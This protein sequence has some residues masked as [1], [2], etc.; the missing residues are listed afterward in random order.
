MSES[1]SHKVREFTEQAGDKTCPS[2]PKPMSREAAL[3]ITRMIVSELDELLCTVSQTPE[4]RD[5]LLAE[6]VATRDR[7]TN[8]SQS[9][10]D[11][12]DL[13]AA[14]FDALVDAW[15]YSLNTAANHGVNLSS[16][17]E[18]VHNANM[19]K[20]DPVTGKFLRRESDGKIIKPT[21]WKSP[22][23]RAEIVRQLK[24]GAWKSDRH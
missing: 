17:F 2:Q 11:Q 4:E 6:A 7:C 18:V 5:Q 21:G 14:Q 19:A 22:D 1:D 13:V 16:I 10:Q 8:F 23:I 20:R 24:R 15:Y 12:P 3:F 9:Y